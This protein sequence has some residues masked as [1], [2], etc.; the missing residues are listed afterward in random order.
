MEIYTDSPQVS[1]SLIWTRM[2]TSPPEI[3]SH[4]PKSALHMEAFMKS[5]FLQ[6]EL[7]FLLFMFVL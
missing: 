5:V 6:A 7:N 2:K 1:V 3:R 4:K